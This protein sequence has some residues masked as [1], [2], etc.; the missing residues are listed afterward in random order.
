MDSFEVIGVSV[1]AT[2]EQIT[3]AWKAAARLTHPDM[4]PEATPEQRRYLNDRMAALNAAYAELS[5]P[6]LRAEARKR[7]SQAGG[8]GAASAREPVGARPAPAHAAAVDDCE[9]CGSIPATQV[10]FQ[11]I[12]GM[13]VSHRVRTLEARLCRSCG[14]GMGREMQ[15][16]TLVSGWWGVIAVFRNA[17]AIFTNA[18]ALHRIG[19]LPPPTSPAGWRTF[20]LP[21]GPTLFRRPRTWIG[22]GLAAV[23]AAAVVQSSTKEPSRYDSPAVGRCVSGYAS[24]EIVPCSASHSGRIIDEAYSTYA[25]PAESESYVTYQG[26]VYCVD[27]DR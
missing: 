25:C 23:L 24:V 12:T 8:A 9:L 3:S 16:R 10:R 20:P 4:F 26:R 21:V 19:Q 27:D 22:I 15:S 13:L 18:A 11:Q 14:Q 2:P 5:D 17:A 6:A 7:R 1:D